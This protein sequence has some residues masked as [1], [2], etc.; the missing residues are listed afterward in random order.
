M[1]SRRSLLF[2]LLSSTP[3]FVASQQTPAPSIASLYGLTTSTTLPFPSAT[4][5]SD[6]TNDILVSSWSLGKGKVQN[7]PNNLAFVDDPF[8]NNPAPVLYGENRTG[9]VLQT[10]YPANT[11]G[12]TDDGAQFINLWNTT[13]GSTFQTMLLTYEVAF[14][15]DFDW[16]KGGKL[17]GLRG[18]WNSTGCSG[19]DQATGEDCFS[20]RL[21]WRTNGEGEVYAYIPSP[22]NLCSSSDI[23][24]NT[25][26][27]IS[28]QRGAYG[29]VSGHY[30]DLKAID[31]QNLQI[32]AN[33][34][35]T[36]N[37]FYFS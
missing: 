2:T 14:P 36:A 18:G 32:R 27:G 21:M 17:P 20:T 3:I 26:Y 9:P 31:Q 16:V 30:N 13:D 4:Q 25:D 37:G 11:F 6:D 23:I 15:S 34:S 33:T 35:V 22:N 12:S 1:F 5:S 7:N 24:C 10:T 8:P 29:F 28:I 19:G